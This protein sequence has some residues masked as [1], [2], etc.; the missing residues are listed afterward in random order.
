MFYLKRL[1]FQGTEKC[2]QYRWTQWFY[3]MKRAPLEK[4]LSKQAR[5]EVWRIEPDAAEVEKLRAAKK[6]C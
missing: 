4:F 3:C 5:P 2:P 1:T 6:A